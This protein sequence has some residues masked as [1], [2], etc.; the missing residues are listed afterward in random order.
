MDLTPNN[1]KQEPIIC[2]TKSYRNKRTLLKMKRFYNENPVDHIDG[3][4]G[5]NT[6]SN[7]KLVSLK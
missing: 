5:N 1:V 6:L 7:L 2:K 4:V 3:D